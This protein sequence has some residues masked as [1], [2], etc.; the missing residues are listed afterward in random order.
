MH[1]RTCARCAGVLTGINIIAT[2]ILIFRVLEAK[3]GLGSF[4]IKKFPKFISSLRY[5]LLYILVGPMVKLFLC[6]PLR[7]HKAL[8][9]GGW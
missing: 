9:G 1:A 3:R 2:Y 6:K 4:G 8:D 7:K 5:N